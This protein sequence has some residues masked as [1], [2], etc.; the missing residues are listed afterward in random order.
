MNKITIVI[1]GVGGCGKDTLVS[2]LSNHYRVKNISSITPVVEVAKFCGWNGVKTEKSRK[3]LSDMKR[4]LTEFNEFSL[5]YL[6]AE[7][8][9]FISGE[10]EIMFVHI[11]EPIEISKFVN[12][13]KTKTYTLLITPRLELQDKVYGNASDDGV[14]DYPYDF[15]FNNDNPLEITENIWLEFVRNNIFHE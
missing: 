8:D 12:N 1:N 10:E 6:L 4:I 13:S 3:F 11:R 5:N 9:K 7:Q 15:I 14:S 2:M